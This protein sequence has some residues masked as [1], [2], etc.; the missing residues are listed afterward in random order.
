[1]NY[2]DRLLKL[3]LFIKENDL[4]CFIVPHSDEYQC[5]FLAPY[6]ERL[7]WLTGF[8]GSAGLAF[9]FTNKAYLFVDGRYTLQAKK[10]IDN[11]YYN[12]KDF[13]SAYEWIVNK[14]IPGMRI[15]YDPRLHLSDDVK[16]LNNN[17]SFKDVELVKVHNNLIDQIWK[18]KPSRPSG[19][20]RIHPI[21]F[22]GL[23]HKNKIKDL[24][25]SFKK[26]NFDSYFIS[27]PDSLC[28]LFNLR[29]NDT[30]FTP[31]LLSQAIITSDMRSIIFIDKERITDNIYK[32]LE[33][34]VEIVSI[35][36]FVEKI[37]SLSEKN[38]NIGVDRNTISDW[39]HEQLKSAGFEVKKSYDLCSMPKSCKNDIEQK[40]MRSA[41]IRDGVALVK[42]LFWL[43][44][45]VDPN[46][47]TELDVCDKLDYLRGQ[48]EYYMGPSF[49][50][51]AAY[52][53]NGAIVH[54]NPSVVSN[55]KIGSS[56]LLLVDS[57]GQYLDGTT[58]VTRTIT[59]G[60]PTAEQ[61]TRFTQV[62]KGHIALASIKFPY[63]TKGG[64]LDILA[65]SA[66]WFDGLDYEHGTGHGVGSY[67]GVH[68][69][70]Q[71]I[72][73][74][75]LGAQLNPGMVLSNE[76]GFYKANEYGIRIENLVLVK[77]F[78][79]NSNSNNNMLHFDT[80]TLAPIDK[81]L[82]KTSSLNSFEIGWLNNYHKLIYEQLKG[83][84][85]SPQR[86]WL[87]KVTEKIRN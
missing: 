16:K 45:E 74:G 2:K 11:N 19:K 80:I 25:S 5:E 71:R 54:Y 1:M 4:D 58:D 20:V 34:D 64:Q 31:L 12:I 46:S 76:P 32:H 18:D 72:G 63:G 55:S 83:K 17:L 15:G 24:V 67:L 57:G 9:I 53:S 26:H 21:E 10:E 61:K 62:L 82:I 33:G 65:R 7:A 39:T 37:K 86:D 84:L 28:W 73:K 77:P 27:S 44:E 23:S 79:S 36:D 81:K 78:V 43:D 40:G 48:N 87:Q 14:A 47:I 70:P 60:V 29:S 68:Q 51:I 42:F 85:D 13:N 30:P 41:H 38:K 52:G 35:K 49:S 50:T 56:S 59:L 75:K 8:T 69:G 6:A 22:S 66:L 3:R